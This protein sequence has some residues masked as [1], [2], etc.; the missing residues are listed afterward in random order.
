MGKRIKVM[1]LSL[2]S[3]L[4]LA[5]AIVYF[6]SMSLFVWDLT[7]RQKSLILDQQTLQAK[8]MAE[9][10]ATSTA[11]WMAAR[12]LAGL[13]EIVEAQLRYPELEFAMLLDLNGQVLAHSDRSY[14]GQYVQDLPSEAKFTMLSH[15]PVLVDVVA[16]IVL[17]GRQV[18]WAR[19]G[20]GQHEAGER[21][22]EITRNGLFYTIGA[23][24][25]GVLIANIMGHRITARIY[26][27]RTVSMA[28]RSGD[29]ESRVLHLGND[30]V[31]Q[32]AQDFNH[33]LDGLCLRECEIERLNADLEQRVYER[34]KELKD[35]LDLNQQLIEVAML[36]ILAYEVTGLCVL[37]NEAAAR[38]VGATVEQLRAQ[39]FRQINSWKQS[40]LLA[41]AED[42]LATGVQQRAEISLVTT[43]GLDIVVD[44]GVSRFETRGQLHLLLTMVD[45]T[46]RKRAEKLRTQLS[47]IIENT[48]DFVATAS[49]QGR[50]LYLNRTAR[51]LFGFS[52]TEDPSRQTIEKSHPPW[53]AKRVLE[54]GIPMAIRNGTWTGDVAF[55]SREG[56]EIPHTQVLIS[57]KAADGTLELMSTIARDISDQKRLELAQQK[58]ID[59]LA[60]SNTDLEQFAFVASHDLKS[61]LRAIDSLAGWLQEDLESALTD[62]NRKHFNLLRQRTHRMERLLEDL[63]AYS[64]AGRGDADISKIDVAQLVSEIA[65]ML[66][67]P[68]GFSL[69][70]VSPMPVFATAVT[71]LRHVLT[72]LI[73]NAV[74]HHDQKV[75]LVEVM[76]RELEGYYAFTVADDGPGIPPEFHERIFGMFQTMRPRDEVEGSGIGLALV[77]RIVIR[78]GGIVTVSCGQDR[79]SLFTFTWPKTIPTNEI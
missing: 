68:E 34:T 43:F 30:E 17:A 67:F 4:I 5:V 56:H 28:V 39:N 53:A 29:K 48:S 78:Y 76:V 71:P 25:I 16:P 10:I 38:C 45:V 59:E 27:I 24:V 13:Q 31:G 75:G 37:A 69:R 55:L 57:H 74:K 64:R 58:L 73:A 8:S 66:N 20:M 63:L 6:V 46:A 22:G 61:P 77:R 47:T 11:G 60:R 23:I 32:L 41:L 65:E 12:D 14:F 79:G 33:M 42:A 21:L 54:E 3:Q 44:C 19:V 2:R 18:G 49:P 15:L 52:D 35:A 62:E 9:M 1:H 40:G 50:I 7:R 72:N 26:A 51:R 70:V 36:G